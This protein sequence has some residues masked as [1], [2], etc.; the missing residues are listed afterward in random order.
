MRPVE[1][2]PTKKF[3]GGWVAYEGPGVE[4]VF[5]GPNGRRDAINYAKGRF[6][7]GSGEIRVYDEGGE[8][9]VETIQIEDNRYG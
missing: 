4:P 6:G 1:I 7:G 2:R 9:V 8:T 3:G 5:P